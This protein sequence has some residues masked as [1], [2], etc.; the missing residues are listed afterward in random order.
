M[1]KKNNEALFSKTSVLNSVTAGYVAGICGTIV[2]HPLDSIKVLLQTNE[3]HDLTS[4][5]CKKNFQKNNNHKR[6]MSTLTPITKERVK[7]SLPFNGRSLRALYSGIS[8]PLL[9]VGAIQ[10]LMFSIYD[11]SRRCFHRFNNEIA[12]SDNDYLN[13]DPL[14]NVFCAA[15]ISGTTLS[16][17]TG[18]LQVIKTKQQIMVWDFQ[19]ALKDTMSMRKLFVG[20]QLHAF[21]AGL[22]RGI[23]MTTYEYLKR[24]LLKQYQN[25]EK[26]ITLAQRAVCAALSGTICWALIFPADVIRT[27]MIAQTITSQKRD[28]HSQQGFSELVRGMYVKGGYTVKPFYRGFSVTLLRAGPVAAAVLPIYDITLQFLQDRQKHI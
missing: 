4:G 10:A 1:A 18:P 5:S 19:R 17:L 27:R 2:G 13:T 21:S 15:V 23:Y 22:G 28:K 26:Q 11:T 12:E 3:C 7:S 6:N 9:S 25:E 8:G 14:L 24:T 16:V 20:N